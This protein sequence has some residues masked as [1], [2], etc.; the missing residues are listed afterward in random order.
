MLHTA[1]IYPEILVPKN[2]DEYREYYKKSISLIEER[3]ALIED[4]ADTDIKLIHY[5]MNCSKQCDECG[6]YN[7]SKHV[8]GLPGMTGFFLRKLGYIKLMGCVVQTRNK[9]YSCN[10]CNNVWE[11]YD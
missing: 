8:Y 1:V 9:R 4:F 5:Y 7:I 2:I 6:T 3:N 11:E 10:D